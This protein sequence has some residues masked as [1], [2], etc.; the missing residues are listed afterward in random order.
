MQ[1]PAGPQQAWAPPG[2]FFPCVCFGGGG[3]PVFGSAI[4]SFPGGG[5]VHRTFAYKRKFFKGYFCWSYS[6][7]SKRIF[8]RILLIIIINIWYFSVFASLFFKTQ[9]VWGADSTPPGAQ[10]I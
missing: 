6:I 2:F 4:S 3:K 10:D 9:S 1:K 5:D 8:L 7:R